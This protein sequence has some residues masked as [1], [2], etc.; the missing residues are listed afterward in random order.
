MELVFS[1]SWFEFCIR[2]KQ[3]YSAM[4]QC[5]LPP[6]VNVRMGKRIWSTGNGYRRLQAA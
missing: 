5:F 4:H 6:A 2:T 1:S 3:K